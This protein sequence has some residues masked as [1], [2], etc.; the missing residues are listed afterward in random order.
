MSSKPSAQSLK[1]LESV[2]NASEM[3][4]GPG[5]TPLSRALALHTAPKCDGLSV[6]DCMR[7]LCMRDAIAPCYE[8]CP[9]TY[10][11]L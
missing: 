11:S 9:G 2:A 7:K 6:Q 10:G 5:G 4:E 8:A 3:S 1:S